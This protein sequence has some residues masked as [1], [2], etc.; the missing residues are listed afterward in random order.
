MTVA[1]RALVA[2]FLVA[3][4]VLSPMPALAQDSYPN[5]PIKLVVP[6]PPGGLIDTLTRMIAE[7]LA[8]K[9]GQ[10]IIVDNKPGASG[11]VGAEL[12][13][14]AKPDGYTLLSSPPPPL[15]LNQ[16][17]FPRLPF[18]PAKFVPI[19]ILTGAPNVLVAHPKVQAD[20]VADL[21]AQAKAHPGK[22]NYA[23]TGNGGTP[24]VTTEWF[25]AA[26]HMQIVHIPY[27]GVKA[28]QAL[29]AG[30]VDVMFI[31]LGDALPTFAAAS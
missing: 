23:S 29:L 27:Q 13:A 17:L 1:P 18:D 2:S 12:V 19:T 9:L 21:I 14:N 4:A 28:L 31:N 7:Q 10:P 8:V 24:H 11:N 26:V 15:V 3:S 22:L 20:N 25:K 16:S 30:E 6:F 5:G